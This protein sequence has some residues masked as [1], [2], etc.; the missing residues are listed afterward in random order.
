MA[1]DVINV[2]NNTLSESKEPVLL[3]N[4]G[5]NTD[6]IRYLKGSYKTF[7]VRCYNI[8]FNEDI[9]NVEW[10][11][12]LCDFCKQ[13][14]ED[15]VVV[16]F[17][18]IDK[19]IGN[20]ARIFD[21]LIVGDNT[22]SVSFPTNAQL[23]FT[24]STYSSEKLNPKYFE[25]CSIIRNSTKNGVKVI[26]SVNDQITE[27]AK[28]A[29]DRALADYNNPVFIIGKKE[30]KGNLDY[31]RSK[32]KSLV[33]DC[34]KDVKIGFSVL[35]D[36]ISGFSRLEKHEVKTG[37]TN[38][39]GKPKTEIGERWV[40][41]NPEWYINL[42]KMCEENKDE[43]VLM[44]FDGI[45][46]MEIGMTLRLYDYTLTD[47]DKFELP[48]NAQLVFTDNSDNVLDPAKRLFYS[49]FFQNC[50]VVRTYDKNNVG[51]DLCSTIEI[52]ESVS[53]ELDQAILGSDVPILIE[54]SVDSL[55]VKYLRNKYKSVVVE[56]SINDTNSSLNAT[57]E[58]KWYTRLCDVCNQNP[59]E[60]VLMIFDE[61]NHATFQNLVDLSEI[62]LDDVHK[63][64][65]PSNAQLVF[66]KSR[67]K[68][69]WNIKYPEYNAF[70][71]NCTI[72]NTCDENN[73]TINPI[74]GYKSKN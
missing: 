40:H 12:R 15:K 4:D 16:V 49:K 41:Y 33:F 5:L 20:D 37:K 71:E 18:G 24:A 21:S 23:I 46:D 26:P 69:E 14:S 74:E 58:P 44:I 36:D 31:L 70:Y 38:L 8:S 54:N 34:K 51:V 29:I 43:K 17:E 53:N 72:I 39:F 48:K 7:V 25:K 22:E 52:S 32:H 10:Y 56:L 66:V 27:E 68:S 6:N 3:L 57:N 50:S 65:M 28:T 13:N 35:G 63:L 42:C 62:T 47:L 19:L 9:K 1:D 55:D 73:V 2:L 67:S 11:T 45:S 60:K 30:S 61:I 64:P 59:E